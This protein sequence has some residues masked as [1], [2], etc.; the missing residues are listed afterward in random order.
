[1]GWEGNIVSPLLWKICIQQRSFFN[2]VWA[3]AQPESDEAESCGLGG[4]RLFDAGDVA[5]RFTNQIYPV[6]A[7]ALGFQQGLIRPQKELLGCRSIAGEA[8]QAAAYGQNPLT[9]RT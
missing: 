2:L 5:L 4:G 1:L 8:C 6:F 9:I 7:A 3:K